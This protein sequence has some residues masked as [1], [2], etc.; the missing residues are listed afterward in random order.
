MNLARGISQSILQRWSEAEQSFNR[1]ISASDEPSLEVTNNQLASAMLYRA[2]ALRRSDRW[3]EAKPL[4]ER[5]IERFG[6]ESDVHDVVG[7][8]EAFLKNPQ[9]ED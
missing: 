1:F 5:L 9:T 4:L 7:R 2:K 8:A 3:S 6:G